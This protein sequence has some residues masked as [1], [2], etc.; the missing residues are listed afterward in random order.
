[1]MLF[2]SQPRRICSAENLRDGA[3]PVGQVAI[4][5]AEAE[6][7]LRLQLNH[8]ALLIERHHDRA[9]AAEHALPAEFGVGGYPDAACR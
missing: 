8:L 7:L 1:M 3:D 2:G 6:R 5:F 9:E 4:A